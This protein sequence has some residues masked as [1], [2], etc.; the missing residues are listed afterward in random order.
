MN[1]DQKLIIITG[2]PGSGKTSLALALQGKL[3]LPLISKD[4]IKETLFDELGY[5]D[6]EWSKKIGKAT[7][8]L[9]DKQIND[10]LSHGISLIVEANFKPEF[11][12]HKFKQWIDTYTCN[13]IQIICTADNKILF[14]RFKQRALDGQ[15]H[16]GHDDINQLDEW[17]TY[18]S[19]PDLRSTPLEIPSK[20]IELDTSDLNTIAV[21]EIVKQL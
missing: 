14:E 10:L 17:S 20:N 19:D 1:K 3:N 18:F 13:A 6:R 2:L 16:P 11:D 7:F 15:R 5:S 12:S 8:S 9:M 4:A 21:D